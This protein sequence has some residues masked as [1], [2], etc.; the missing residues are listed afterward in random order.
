MK[1][2]ILQLA[3]FILLTILVIF[4][5]N[6]IVNVSARQGGFNL[7][8]SEEWHI[9]NTTYA[10]IS[11]AADM[12]KDGIMEIVT[13]GWYEDGTTWVGGNVRHGII[14][15]WTWNGTV[16]ELKH[17]E[18]WNASGSY[19]TRLITWGDI[20]DVDDDGVEELITAGQTYTAT[21]INQ[22]Q[23]ELAIWT[24]NGSVLE[25]EHEKR[26]HITS[27]TAIT[28]VDVY[29]VDDD[30]TKEIITLGLNWMGPTHLIYGTHMRIWNWNGNILTLEHSEEIYD[31]SQYMTC[32]T[33]SFFADIDND[34]A[35][36]IVIAGYIQPQETSN[37]GKGKVWIWNW[38]GMSLIKEHSKEWSEDSITQASPNAFDVIADDFDNDGIIEVVTCGNTHISPEH[39]SIW[40]W[41]WNGSTF[42]L[43]H[44][45]KWNATNGVR[46]YHSTT[47]DVNED[48]TTELV[49]CGMSHS[50]H[51]QGQLRVWQWNTTEGLILLYSAEWAAQGAVESY[52]IYVEDVDGDSRQ[53]IITTGVANDGTRL[54]GQLRIWYLPIT[55]DHVVNWDVYSFDVTTL[56]NST[57]DDFRFSQPDKHISFNVTVP[58]N[59]AGYCNLTIPMEMLGGP[60]VCLIDGSPI[61]SVETSNSTHVSLY[62]NY[63]EDGHV[64][65]TGTTVIAE[66]PTGTVMLLIFVTITACVDLYRRKRLKRHIG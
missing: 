11:P 24:W 22:F 65:I 41:T 52:S 25:R 46:I 64:E 3:T 63:L 14:K 49:T 44:N 13:V 37:V 61:T 50:N 16:L 5:F 7:E 17:T 38:N 18:I 6:L 58:S 39:G 54:N 56:S 36:E 47:M 59:M 29:D 33:R 34:G 43:L 4:G 66:F 19:L 15:I 40:I 30:G 53:E 2:K 26:W 55:K 42:T 62:I 10:Y 20:A 32:Q 48:G 1:R 23:A 8:Y 57:I 9:M 28:N 60:Y 51:R 27:A 31:F 35:V 45:E 12:D 21:P